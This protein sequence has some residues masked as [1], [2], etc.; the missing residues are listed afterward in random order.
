MRCVHILIPVGPHSSGVEVLNLVRCRGAE[1]PLC[2]RLLR[3]V[4]LNIAGV[5]RRI[6]EELSH[7]AAAELSVLAREFSRAHILPQLRVRVGRLHDEIVTEARAEKTDLIVLAAPKTTRRM[8]LFNPRTV[9]R[10]VRNA[11]CPTLVLPRRQAMPPATGSVGTET[12]CTELEY[13]FALDP[14]LAF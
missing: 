2:V 12:N 3:V 13:G 5:D 7:E 14:A 6:Y 4:E 9:E 11:P 8:R 1:N 10:V